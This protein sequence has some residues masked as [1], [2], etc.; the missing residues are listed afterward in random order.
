VWEIL[1]GNFNAGIPVVLPP[2]VGPGDV[3]SGAKG[4]WGLRAYS[5]ATAGTKAINLRASGNNATSDFNTLTNGNLDL[6]SI[7]S[8]LMANGGSLFVTKLYDQSGGGLDMAQATA[9][10][11]PQFN[12][13]VLGSFPSMG[14]V[15]ASNLFL[16]ASPYTIYAQPWTINAVARRTGNTANYNAIITGAVCGD[17]FTSTLTDIDVETNI[18]IIATGLTESNFHAIVGVGN[19]ATTASMIYADGVTAGPAGG[20]TSF[21]GTSNIVYLGSD[22]AGPDVLTGNIMEGGLWNIAFS[23]TQATNMI[24]NQRTYWGF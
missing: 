4:W 14:F 2:Y 19:G 7:N 9:A 15:N 1:E 16:S 24:S 21:P 20:T 3:V 13:S 12:S 10:N 23:S 5:R 6:A 22:A 17:W 11:Q 8:F 18:G